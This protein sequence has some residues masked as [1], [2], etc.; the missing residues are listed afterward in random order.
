MTSNTK[1]NLYPSFNTKGYS[2][3]YG[4]GNYAISF[5]NGEDIIIQE[6]FYD[7]PE[8]VS[9]DTKTYL[10]AKDDY[11]RLAIYDSGNRVADY[12]FVES[13]KDIKVMNDNVVIVTFSDNK[14]EKAVIDK[15]DKFTVEQGVHICIIKKFLSRNFGDNGS[16]IYNKLIKYS[17]NCYKDIT[18]KKQKIEEENLRKKRRADK[19]KAKRARLKAARREAEI[20]IQKEA[21]LRAIRELNDTSNTTRLDG[22]DSPEVSK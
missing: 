5:K 10:Y 13:I 16:S 21:Y 2:S 8:K 9:K 20:E 15:D 18:A 12:I 11:I 17:S 22:N 7:S 4:Y 14:V 1:S 6:H 3:N 19:A